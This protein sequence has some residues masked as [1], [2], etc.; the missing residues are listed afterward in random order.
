MTLVL[1]SA[2]GVLM[3]AAAAHRADGVL[4]VVVAAGL[5]AVLAAG[6]WR[7]AATAAVLVTVL[8]VVLAD[9]APM[10]TALA[11]L[12]ATAYLVLRHGHPTRPTMVFA[13]GF[14]AVAAIAVVAPVNVAWLPL[15]APLALLAGYLVALRPF[16]AHPASRV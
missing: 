12:S 5:I 2:F 4:L 6:V 15:A 13:V 16:L 7:P 14:A 3:I 9:P 11:G 10:Y 8:I 1:P